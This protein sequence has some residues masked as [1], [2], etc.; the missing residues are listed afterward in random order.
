MAAHPAPTPEPTTAPEFPLLAIFAGL[1]VV[2]I[3]PIA[4]VIAAPS[5][6]TLVAALA[7]VAVFAIAISALLARIIG[8]EG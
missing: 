8:P 6:V 3:V 7:T 5:I 1:I 4:L 2:A